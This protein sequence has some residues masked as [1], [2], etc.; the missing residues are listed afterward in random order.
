MAH[1]CVIDN[2]LMGSTCY[3]GQQQ[4]DMTLGD[5]GQKQT[6]HQWQE[7]VCVCVLFLIRIF[8]VIFFSVTHK[9]GLWNK[10]PILH[11]PSTLHQ[12]ALPSAQTSSGGFALR[13]LAALWVLNP[14]SPDW[15]L[16]CSAATANLDT[17]PRRSEGASQGL[18]TRLNFE[19]PWFCQEV[20]QP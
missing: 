12:G 5:K 9:R 1:L 20:S 15:T 16:Q 19:S 10:I 13:S 2:C 18:R 3:A 8:I 14:G 6:F 11:W 7:L 4:L 17:P